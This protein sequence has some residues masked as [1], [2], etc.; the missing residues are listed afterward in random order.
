MQ[1]VHARLL[2]LRE[3]FR[4][5]A[6][7]LSNQ[8]HAAIAVVV[9]AI[10]LGLFAYSGIGGNQRAG[11]LFLQDIEQRTL[12]LRFALRGKRA[13]D[14]RIVIVGIDD[15]TLQTIGSYP[16]PRSNYALLVRELK[17][18]GASVVGFDVTF[19]TAASSEAL[20]VLARLR[21]EIGPSAPARPAKQSSAARATIRC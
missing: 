5:A 21:S 17:K 8:P 10:G 14:P 1:S 13:A 2:T 16:L 11:F 9:T 4:V 18:S 6:R 3:H 20:D 15:K 19:P 12:D 7:W